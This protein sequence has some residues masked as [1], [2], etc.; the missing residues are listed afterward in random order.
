MQ[1]FFS[2]K[3]DTTTMT[4]E[5][6]EAAQK[7]VKKFYLDLS[8]EVQLKKIGEHKHSSSN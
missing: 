5:E 8:M 6:L 3:I 7:K 2:I 4:L 1:E